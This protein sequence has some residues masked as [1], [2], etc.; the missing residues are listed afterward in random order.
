MIDVLTH[1]V[2]ACI[3]GVFVL[4]GYLALE[5]DTEMR[6]ALPPAPRRQLPRAINLRPLPGPALE[7]FE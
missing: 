5:R 4:A 6:R 1:L 7:D 2:A 3:G